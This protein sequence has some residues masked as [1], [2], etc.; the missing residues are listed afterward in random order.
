M[1][2]R[3][4]ALT[5]KIL[6]IQ[7][8][9]L[10]AVCLFGVSHCWAESPEN[11]ANGARPKLPAVIPPAVAPVRP[12][13]LPDDQAADEQ[14]HDKPGPLAEVEQFLSPSGLTPTLKVMLLL[15]LLSVA[16][17]VLV[18]TTSFVRFVIVFGLLRQALGTQ[19]LPPN[20][21]VMSLSLFLTLFV[22]TPV[23]NAAYQ[24]GIKPYVDEEPI[25][26]IQPGEERLTRVFHN[27][28]K[29]VQHFMS[30]QIHKAH[31][32]DI[33]WMLIDFRRPNPN[34]LAGKQFQEPANFEDVEPSI[35]VTAFMLSEL[36]AAFILG[37]QIFLPFLVIDFVVSTL[38]TSMGMMMMP[39]TLVSLPFK[40]LLFVLID[41]WTLITH[42]LLTSVVT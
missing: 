36:K 10:I 24:E 25:P 34:S 3:R 28:F 5:S 13:D 19:Q 9:T 41:G 23:W 15:S 6:S 14:R 30:E 21:V 26:N 31:G 22:M 27:T 38:L 2:D 7:V 39:P 20:Q 42:M 4:P 32:E 17:A 40:I 8:A 35:I 11:P 33:V 29:P 1:F 16:P 37:F 12:A 18:M